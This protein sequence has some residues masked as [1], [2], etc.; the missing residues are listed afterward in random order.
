MYRIGTIL[1]NSDSSLPL[2]LLLSFP[3]FFFLIFDSIFL[4]YFIVKGLMLHC[5]KSSIGEKWKDHRSVG[6]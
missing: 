4:T 5:V 6:I 2:Y 1:S 3:F